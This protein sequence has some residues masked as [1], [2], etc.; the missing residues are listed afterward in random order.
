MCL[1]CRRPDSSNTSLSEGLRA[2]F[3][4]LDRQSALRARCDARR[5]QGVVGHGN[6]ACAVALGGTSG[7]PRGDP[8]AGSAAARRGSRVPWRARWRARRS[9]GSRVRALR[10][11]FARRRT[12]ERASSCRLSS[13]H[14]TE[15]GAPHGLA[16]RRL[17]R[18]HGR[19][20]G[21]ARSA[22]HPRTIPRRA[23]AASP[24]WAPG[25]GL[26]ARASMGDY[27]AHAS[28]QGTY[29]ETRA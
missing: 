7:R 18:G 16:D 21:A 14:V 22:P 8:R 6:R 15:L 5:G 23:R 27:F 2:T 28:I 20:R 4:A 10:R 11:R 3:R 13:P 25:T 9:D 26:T 17:G 24:P 19:A 1:P 12:R 29:F